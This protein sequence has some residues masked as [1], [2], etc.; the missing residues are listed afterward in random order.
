MRKF[1]DFGIKPISDEGMFAVDVIHL[2]Q[3]INCE[4][5]ILD[6]TSGVKTQHG[7]NRYVVKI[8]HEGKEWKF[9]TNAAPIK[10]A[11]DQIPKTEFPFKTTIKQKSFGSSSTFELT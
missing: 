6:F 5:I 4:I 8:E 2:P 7:E 3:I 10:N 9:F 1:S 11:L